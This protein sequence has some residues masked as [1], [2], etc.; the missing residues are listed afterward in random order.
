MTTDGDPS[1]RV[2]LRRG[3]AG[4]AGP[5]AP[6]VVAGCDQAIRP[7]AAGSGSG[8]APRPVPENS[9]PGDPDW[10]ISDLGAPNAIMGYAGQSSVLPGEPVDLYVSTTSREFQVTA[11]RIGWYGGGLAP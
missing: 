6:G 10:W 9:L 7:V 3:P 1:R 11:F 5:A 4:A 2:F 8:A